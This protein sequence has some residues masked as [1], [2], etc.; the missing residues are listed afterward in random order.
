MPEGKCTWCG[1]EYA[2]W[3]LNNPDQRTCKCGGKIVLKE[4]E[5]CQKPI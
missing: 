5:P 4:E 3:A 1:Q 2:G